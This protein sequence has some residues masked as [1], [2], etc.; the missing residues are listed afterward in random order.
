MSLREIRPPDS[1]MR[2]FNGFQTDVRPS[3]DTG[4]NRGYSCWLS[5]W[6]SIDPREYC[7]AP[8]RSFSL[9]SA[10]ASLRPIS[11]P[12]NSRDCLVNRSRSMSA[13][14]TPS[15]LSLLR[16]RP[17]FCRPSAKAANRRMAKCVL[18]GQ[19]SRYRDTRDGRVYDGAS[20][21]RRT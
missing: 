5:A 3:R 9:A 21:Q 18:W 10:A 4:D 11:T 14:R 1:I 19:A 7:A 12:Q 16:F 13:P 15:A 17:F 6:L 8:P 2:Y 20:F